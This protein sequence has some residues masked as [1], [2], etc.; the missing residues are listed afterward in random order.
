VRITI[1]GGGGFR[2]PLICDAIASSGLAVSSV[3]LYDISSA[4]LRVISDVLAGRGL[5]VRTTVSLDEALLGADVVFSAFRAG[6]TDGR[7]SDERIALELGI[8]GQETVGAG[9]LRGALRTIPVADALARRVA[10]LAPDA[11]VISMTNPAG[12]VTEVMTETLG[13][14]VIGVCDSP[15]ALVRRACV[16]AGIDPGPS[17]AGVAEQVDADYVGI[18]HLGWL[19]ALRTQGADLLPGLLADDERVLSMEEGR[20]FGPDLLRALGA[21]PNEYLY[22]YYAEREALDGVRQ[23]GRTRGEHVRDRQNAFYAAAAADPA[24]AAALWADANDERNRSYFAELRDGERDAADVAVGGYE[25]VAVALA[26]A[27]TGNAPPARLILNVHNDEFQAVLETVCHVDSSGARPIPLAEPPSAH[28]LGLMNA[29][30]RCE[31]DIATAALT[32]SAEAALRAFA[33]HPLVGS[34]RAARALAAALPLNE[35]TY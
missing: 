35:N 34:L 8:L 28:Q 1:V 22:W 14:R 32:G 33:L 25:T 21:I 12:I 10:E 5:P 11:W 7:V 6:G 13:N 15:V 18:N 27:L 9:G 30:R 20:L 19:R 26:A 24:S 2:T 16:A 4:R 29:V 3:V 17:L 31:R 23:A